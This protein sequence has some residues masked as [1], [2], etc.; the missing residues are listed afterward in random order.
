[1]VN[2]VPNDTKEGAAANDAAFEKI[3]QNKAQLL[4]L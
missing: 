2:G 1:M 3:M 4:S